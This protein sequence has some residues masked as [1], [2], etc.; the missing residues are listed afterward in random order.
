MIPSLYFYNKENFL[1]P[2][3]KKR[4]KYIISG[5]FFFF[6]YFLFILSVQTDG[7]FKL[8]ECMMFLNY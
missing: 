6:I 3:Y 5:D 4:N 1:C 7:N 2:S 8:P